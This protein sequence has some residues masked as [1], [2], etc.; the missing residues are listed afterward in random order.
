MRMHFL[1]LILLIPLKLFSLTV[2][3]PTELNANVLNS[4]PLLSLNQNG[5]AAVAWSSGTRGNNLN[6]S[7]YSA[8]AQTWTTFLNLASGGAALLEVDGSGNAF[9]VYNATTENNIAFRRYDVSTQF[10]SE[11]LLI[12]NDNAALHDSP[13][14]SVNTNGDALVTWRI[15]GSFSSFYAFYDVTTGMFSSPQFLFEDKRVTQA[16]IDNLGGGFVTYLIQPGGVMT[17]APITVP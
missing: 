10:W 4:R 5:D 15:T 11:Q 2:G 14:L 7:I 13:T 8:S 17:V 12:S 16:K 6:V 3:T 1:F 9:L